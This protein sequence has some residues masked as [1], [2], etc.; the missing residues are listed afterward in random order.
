MENTEKNQ[1]R[2]YYTIDLLHIAKALWER[3]WVII[4]AAIIGAAA[5]FSYSSFLIAPTYSSTIM[6]YVNNSSFS[7][8]STNVSISSSQIM[9]A[10]SLVNTYTEILNNR[11]TYERVIQKAGVDYT[12]SQLAGMVKA[13]PSNETEIMKV[14]VTTT[15][16]QE[17]A[18]IANCIAE[19]LPIRIAEIIDGASMEVVDTAV[20]NTHKVAPSVTKYTAI[21]LI[22]GAIGA[23]AVLAIFAIMDD[24]IHDEEYILQNYKYPVLSKL[25]DLLDDGSGRYGYR[26]RYRYYRSRYYKKHYGYYYHRRNKTS[27][28][29]KNTKD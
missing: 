2:E 27:D 29:Q 7:I 21:G 6:L 18:N 22:L 15:D 26:Y 24:T 28:Q 12:P 9:A 23:A 17:A 14:T 8:G 1:N 16:P 4:L 20:P 25:P 11:T 10:Q 13:G 19:V 3:M 5:G